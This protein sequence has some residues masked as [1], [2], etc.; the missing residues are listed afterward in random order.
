M[1]FAEKRLILEWRVT[2]IYICIYIYI[3]IY[4]YM[5]KHQFFVDTFREVQIVDLRQVLVKLVLM[6]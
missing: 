1:S 6:Y 5:V 3:Y 4:I 2:Y